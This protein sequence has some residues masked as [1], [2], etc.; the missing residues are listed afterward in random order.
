L[1]DALKQVFGT[2]TK[3]FNANSACVGVK[4]GVTASTISNALTFVFSNYNGHCERC[5]ECNEWFKSLLL[6]VLTIYHAIN[7][8]VPTIMMKKS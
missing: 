2:S 8:F 1:E 5:S 4:I 3:L 6:T 7:I